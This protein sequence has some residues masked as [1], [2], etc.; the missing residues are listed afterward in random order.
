M[1]FEMVDVC[2]KEYACSSVRTLLMVSGNTRFLPLFC[3]T[4][5]FSFYY[6]VTTRQGEVLDCPTDATEEVFTTSLNS[7]SEAA[8]VTYAFVEESLGTVSFRVGFHMFC[9]AIDAFPDIDVSHPVLQW[10]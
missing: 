9:A 10:D 4:T 5:S 8:G 2:F 3:R 7:I 1:C 6:E